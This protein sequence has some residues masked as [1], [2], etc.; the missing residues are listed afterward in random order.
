[1]AVSNL[2]RMIRAELSVVFRR[3]SSLGA[4]LSSV[5]IGLLA[6]LL[7]SWAQQ[8]MSGLEINEAPVG[9]MVQYSGA[10]CAGWA[11]K[12]RNFFVLPL[13]LLLA[14]GSSIAGELQDRSLREVLV[15]AVPRWQ[16]LLA[17]LVALQVLSACS[18]VLTLLPAWLLGMAMF[19]AEGANSAVLLGYCASLLTD[20]GIISFGALASLYVRSVG[21]VVVCVILL[22]ML[23]TGL[24]IVLWLRDLLIGIGQQVAGTVPTSSV[25][26]AMFFPGAAL[27]FW[28]GWENGWLWPS[29]AGLMALI[30]ICLAMTT[31]RFQRM[32]VP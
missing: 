26:I 17:K 30:I 32:D 19:G 21:G 2:G 10:N 3:T 25:D 31:R 23:D 5:V 9:E 20:L 8:N 7:M 6:V 24:R 16:V 22:L 15:R 13:L 12:G 27:D 14:T 18:L 11:L 1:M 28:K 29:F 4:L